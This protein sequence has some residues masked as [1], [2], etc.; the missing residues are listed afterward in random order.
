MQVYLDANTKSGEYVYFFPNEAAYYFL[1]DRNNPTRYAMSYF[2]ITSSQRRE[3]VSELEIN[4]PTYV[5]YSRQTWRI[6]D[7]QAKV[8]VPEVISYLNDK[9]KITRNL[10][11]VVI[12]KRIERI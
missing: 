12:A 2:A 7:I 1:L 10:G 4:K 9:Y 3:L 8:Q 6:D 11:N 5:V